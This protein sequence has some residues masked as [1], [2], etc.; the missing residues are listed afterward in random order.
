ME[1]GLIFNIQRY[2]VEDGPGI[3]TTVFLKGC[4]LRCAWCHNP[5]GLASEPEIYV[6]ESMCLACGKCR[7]VCPVSLVEKARSP[8]PLPPRVAGCQ[9]C[10]ACV[11]ECPPHARRMV[12]QSMT[13]TQV[14]D[15]ILRDRV[16]FEDSGGGVTFSGGEPLMQPAFLLGLL[17]ACRAQGI[18]T[19]VDT[20]GLAPYEH[21]LA[22]A[23]LVDLFLYDLKL[24]DDAAHRRYTGV[25]NR[26]ILENLSKLGRVHRQI[27]L[28]VPCVAGVNDQ[29]GELRGAAQFAASVPGVRQVTLLPFHWLGMHKRRRIGTPVTAPD[30]R[31]PSADEMGRAVGIFQDAG[32]TARAGG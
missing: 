28:R 16:F 9:L 3:R 4:P 14:L 25:S 7:Q 10:G 5:E 30:F 24:M 26:L 17:Q 27:W 19:V 21:L 11:E 15:V 22:I 6:I 12:G 13:V 31:T 23:P 2:S 32:L 20:S 29:A 8:E 1:S 18:H